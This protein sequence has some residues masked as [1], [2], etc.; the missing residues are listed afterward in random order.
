[1][2][3]GSP[4]TPPTVTRNGYDRIGW[5]PAVDETVPDHDVEYVAK[6]NPRNFQ[7]TFMANGGTPETT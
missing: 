6:W 2:E 3:Y 5:V 1:M 7:I 4:I